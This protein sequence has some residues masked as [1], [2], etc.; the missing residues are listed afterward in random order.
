MPIHLR[1]FLGVFGL[2]LLV[3]CSSS[4]NPNDTDILPDSDINTQDSETIDD[5]SDL[6]EAEFVDDLE[7]EDADDN[8]PT[9]PAEEI[10][11]DTEPINGYKRCYDKIPAGPYEG[12]FADPNLESQ[13]K[14]ILGY[15]E[16]YE[17]QEDDLEKITEIGFSTKDLRGVEKLVNL[18]YANFNDKGGGGNIYDFTPLANLKKLKK[19]IIR[20]R[21]PEQI[22]PN[23]HIVN[24]TCLDG[25]FSLLTNLETLEIRK[26]HLK[27][28]DPI[29]QCVNLKSLDL[30]Y[31]RLKFLPENLGNLQK[32]EWFAFSYNRVENIEPL[33]SLTNLKELFFHYNY[34]EDISPIKDLVNLTMLGAQGNKIK[35]ISEIT[36][37]VNL[38]YLGFSEN[39]IEAIPKDFVNLK[40]LQT[41]ELLYNHISNLPELKGLDSLIEM[42]IGSNDLNDEDLMKLDDLESVQILHV[43]LCKKITKV[44]VMKNL[45]SLQELY[46]N[47][48]SITDLSGFA[49]NESFPAL[50]SVYLGSN[51]ISDA[52]ALRKR[53]GLNRL[54][55]GNNCISDLSPLEELKE[56]GTYISGM[57]EQLESCENTTTLGNGE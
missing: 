19:I 31:N 12:F 28:V 30:L 14:Q 9:E 37:L 2:F 45:K 20:F 54:S 38:T 34:V 35:N 40:K 55:I 10:F 49:D 6:Q 24:M 27:E 23:E 52:E 53:K 11:E 1:L 46:L 7:Q 36:T 3:S 41:C 22:S 4:K 42:K 51:K 44:P 39:Q 43:P 18:E 15:D 48:N 56:G 47:Y 17:L 57:N 50:K 25:S 16:D 32:L 26:T 29:E 13:I 33:K 5:D 21:P 8:E